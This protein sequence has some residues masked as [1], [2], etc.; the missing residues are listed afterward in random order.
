MFISVEMKS[1]NIFLY[2][3]TSNFPATFVYEIEGFCSIKLKWSKYCSWILFSIFMCLLY[4][5]VNTPLP[6]IVI[7]LTVSNQGR[8]QLCYFFLT[9]IHGHL[10]HPCKFIWIRIPRSKHIYSWMDFLMFCT[11]FAHFIYCSSVALQPRVGL[12]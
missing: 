2:V 1:D 5:L 9:K 8:H 3:V 12:D 10:L 6:R 4:F 11:I 7:V